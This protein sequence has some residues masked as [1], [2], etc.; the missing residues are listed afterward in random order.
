MKFMDLELIQLWMDAIQQS[1]AKQDLMDEFGRWMKGEAKE[2][3][4]LFGVFR[5]Y[6]SLQPGTD[7]FTDYGNQL[8]EVMGNFQTSFKELLSILGVVPKADYDR[9]RH[10]Y[11]AIKE[12]AAGLEEM[13]E[14]L[15]KKSGKHAADG[16]EKANPLEDLIKAQTDQFS[17]LM[18][19]FAG[20]SGTGTSQNEKK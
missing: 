9:L 6:Y 4:E 20:I 12:K 16:S 1:T 19:S 11:E 2:T 14:S 5:K 17:K 7:A 8:K 3:D 15:R 10:E 18:N 13:V